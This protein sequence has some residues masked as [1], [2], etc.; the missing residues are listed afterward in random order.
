[1]GLEISRMIPLFS[2]RISIQTQ[3]TVISQKA[4]FLFKA[5]LET[6]TDDETNQFIDQP[7]Q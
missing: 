4:S 7:L 2:P 5:G 3:S 6:I 1:M